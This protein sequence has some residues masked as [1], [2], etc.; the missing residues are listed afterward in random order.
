MAVGGAVGWARPAALRGV[1][2]LQG[3]T[4]FGFLETIGSL[5]MFGAAHE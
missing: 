3:A 1:L 2:L 4:H 5:R